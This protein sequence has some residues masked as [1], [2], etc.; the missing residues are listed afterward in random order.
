MGG[1]EGGR[2]YGVSPLR[3]ARGFIQEVEMA[4]HCRQECWFCFFVLTFARGGT[5]H[6]FIRKAPKHDVLWNFGGGGIFCVGSY[7]RSVLEIH[8]RK[9]K[10]SFPLSKVFLSGWDMGRTLDRGRGG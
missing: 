7:V 6:L 8:L 4:K 1:V 3:E 10:A 9:N 2:G 5:Q